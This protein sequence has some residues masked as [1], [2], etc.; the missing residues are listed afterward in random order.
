MKVAI[1]FVSILLFWNNSLSSQFEIL[2]LNK[3]ISLLDIKFKNIDTS[4]IVRFSSDN[5]AVNSIT[6]NYPFDSL[7]TFNGIKLNAIKYI[8][9]KNL[10]SIDNFHNE[11]S[12]DIKNRPDSCLLE[13]VFRN[14]STNNY[15]VFNFETSIKLPKESLNKIHY[16]KDSLLLDRIGSLNSLIFRN[17]DWKKVAIPPP[18]PPPTDHYLSRVQK[19]MDDSWMDWKLLENLEAKNDFINA[20][21][22]LDSMIYIYPDDDLLVYQ[23]IKLYQKH[24]K[25][26][27]TYDMYFELLRKK[28]PLFFVNDVSTICELA[29]LNGHYGFVSSND[30]LAY[31][32]DFEAREKFL[33]VFHVFLSK[34]IQENIINQSEYEKLMDLSRF[35]HLNNWNFDLILEHIKWSNL[36]DDIKAKL[37]FIIKESKKGKVGFHSADLLK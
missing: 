14:K 23:K 25:Y 12:V 3:R 24:N 37:V 15:I 4:N 5:N 16:L 1:I 19:V 27:E 11:K 10:D 20:E 22:Y 33:L 2:S 17:V 36:S 30:F 13:L 26:L 34:T 6:L 35:Y 7:F 8:D 32:S 28:S 21:S 29:I 9:I 31:K 18:P